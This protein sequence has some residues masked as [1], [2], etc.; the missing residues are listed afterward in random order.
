[1]TNEELETISGNLYSAYEQC[2]SGTA[3]CVDQLMRE[4]RT[5]P[6]LRALWFYTPDAQVY[7][8]DNGTP[9]LRITRENNNPVL[10]DRC[11]DIYHP[12]TSIDFEVIKT[13][14][15]T[16]TID[17]TQLR[18]QDQDE[19]WSYLVVDTSKSITEYN[20]E[21]QKLLRRVFGPTDDDYNKNLEMWE[22][23]HNENP[24]Y[25]PFPKIYLLNPNSVKDR[26][27]K[28]P[29]SNPERNPIMAVI[30]M[31]SVFYESEGFWN[32]GCRFTWNLLTCARF[33]AVRRKESGLE[34]KVR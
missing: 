9:T 4:R 3:L 5:D 18:L 8:M 7:S 33:R 34:Q 32:Y 27:D 14:S 17:L 19:D 21:E 26:I 23:A 25:S 1:M 13:A 24:Y 6:K 11:I 2:V 31:D 30:S 20:A 10:R 28:C 15:D 29:Y 16:V 12:V 22:T